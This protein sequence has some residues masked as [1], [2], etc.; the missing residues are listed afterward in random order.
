[1]VGLLRGQDQRPVRTPGGEQGPERGEARAESGFGPGPREC[2]G[3]G[4]HQ[5]H[6][7]HVRH[8]P[9]E[10]EM[11]LARHVAESDHCQ[12]EQARFSVPIR[13]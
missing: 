10:R 13:W 1:M 3:I 12:P 6:H 7:L 9:E 4:V 2:R 11:D 5:A 8:T